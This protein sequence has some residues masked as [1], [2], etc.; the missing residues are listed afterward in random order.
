[1][2][3]SVERVRRRTG[4]KSLSRSDYLFGCLVTLRDRQT[5][6]AH[7]LEVLAHLGNFAYD[8]FNH[9]F[10]QPHG[11][12]SLLMATI[13][14]PRSGR[15]V[16]LRCP[17]PAA[18]RQLLHHATAGLVN[19][20]PGINVGPPGRDGSA[21]LLQDAFSAL[22]AACRAGAGA[23][24]PTPGAPS[25]FFFDGVSLIWLACPH[26]SP[27]V[28]P[29]AVC[30]D[31]LLQVTQSAGEC[32]AVA[33][34]AGCLGDRLRSAPP[35]GGPAMEW[36]CLD[37]RLAALALALLE[38]LA[39]GPRSRESAALLAELGA[40]IDMVDAWLPG[41]EAVQRA[42]A[43]H[44]ADAVRHAQSLQHPAA[45]LLREHA[46]TGRPAVLRP[47][48]QAASLAAQL[49]CARQSARLAAG[50]PPPR[51]DDGQI[52]SEPGGETG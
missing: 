35:D 2:F 25:A 28:P 29:C 38:T 26:G 11:F 47:L 17:C 50:A 39:A 7:R 19:I 3:T 43:L 36:A 20:L 33:T 40:G 27:G 48:H 8:P 46:P 14:D 32:C 6:D 31:M 51:R 44:A 34:N 4:R 13:A 45:A 22:L 52:P 1:M 24:A 30:R 23:C 10:L 41:L 21:G 18:V 42:A 49:D 16:P 5:D 12:S 37:L 9:R 15:E